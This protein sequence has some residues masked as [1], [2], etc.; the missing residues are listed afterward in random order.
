MNLFAELLV[1]VLST[2]KLEL[3]V[4]GWDLETLAG[5]MNGEALIALTQIK[6]ILEDDSLSDPECFHKIEAIVST[7]EC[8]GSGA[9]TRHDFG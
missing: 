5:A 7:L 4:V 9:G 1:Y 6:D 8:I 3:E 2:R